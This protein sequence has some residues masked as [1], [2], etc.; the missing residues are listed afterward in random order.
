[1]VKIGVIS[2]MLFVCCICLTLQAQDVNALF[3]EAEAFEKSFRDDDALNKYLEI[4]RVNPRNVDA[5]SKASQLYSVIGKRYDEKNKQREYYKKAMDYASAALK[6]N[7]NSSE[8]NFA[9]AVSKG[10]MAL[11][12]GGE[13]KI[14]AVKDIKLYADRCVQLDP[15]N[16]KGYHVLAKWHFEVSDLSSLERWLVKVT[17][18]ALP[19]ASL[20]DAVRFYEK[21]KQLAPGFLLNYLELAKAYKRKK[22]TKRA[23]ILLEQLQKLPPTGSD[24]PKIK[25]LGKKL[26]DEL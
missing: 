16:Y 2:F 6:L 8:A 25:S 7:P 17:Y 19:P 15:L 24:D 4:I 21:S 14:K 26:L 23:R 10:R 1:M 3:K 20:D 11:I 9:M 12:A 13:E 5:H 18:G 22:D